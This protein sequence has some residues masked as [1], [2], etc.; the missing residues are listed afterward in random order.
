MRARL[1][2][3][4]MLVVAG[5]L[6]A[7][8]GARLWPPPDAVLA[9][10]GE[11]ASVEWGEAEA[12]ASGR[13]VPFRAVSSTGIAVSGLLNLG[14]LGAGPA[15]A[16]PRLF[17]LLGGLVTASRAARLVA[18]PP[19]C[20]LAALDYPYEG[21]RRLRSF[22]EFLRGLP[23]MLAG[24]R[25]T[26]AAVSLAAAALAEHPELRGARVTLMGVSFGSP[27]AI[28][29]AASE[30]V[31]YQGL[32]LLYGFADLRRLVEHALRDVHWP[33]PARA[34]AA[35]AIALI[36]RPIE[37]ARHL[38][39]VAPLP[40]LLVNGSDDRFV[41]HACVEALERAA[42]PPVTVHTLAAGHVHPDR[43]ELIAELTRLVIEW[44]EV[45]GRPREGGG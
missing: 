39:R 31:R 42:R 23:A 38:G 32:A 13:L 40:V 35:R 24:V 8:V 18:P 19:G 26:P 15:T 2:L 25:A 36:L 43:E 6:V 22:G 37:P 10:R 27:F 11:L 9:V 30:P 7:G 41:P 28:L 33:R 21:P 4:I 17:V 3:V 16:P 44:A 12:A 5:A 45:S 29:A 1:G 14:S 20:A 34:L